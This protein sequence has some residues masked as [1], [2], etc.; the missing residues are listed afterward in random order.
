MMGAK[1]FYITRLSI[2]T[3]NIIA[4]S[5]NGLYVTLSINDIEHNRH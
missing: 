4:L 5:V 3:F 1:T 2:M